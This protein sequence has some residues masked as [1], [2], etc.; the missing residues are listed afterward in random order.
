MAEHMDGR[1]LYLIHELQNRVEALERQRDEA[2]KRCRESA[3][4]LK[5]SATP[6]PKKT[7]GNEVVDDLYDRSAFNF[8]SIAR[9]D[10][11]GT[12]SFRHED[13]NTILH[14]LKQYTAVA[15]DKAIAEE[16]EACAKT[17][18]VTPLPL[19][20]ESIR[21]AVHDTRRY[22]WEAIRSRE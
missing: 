8:V 18:E 9:D 20:G 13:A 17:V 12:Y 3:S 10:G 5:P 6:P 22:L 16:R 2:T 7:K 11:W 19:Y 14:Y 1:W 21:S 4:V 15:V